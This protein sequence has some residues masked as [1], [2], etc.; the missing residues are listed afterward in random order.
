MVVSCIHN[1]RRADSSFTWHQQCN[2]YIQRCKYIPK[3]KM[4]WLQSLIQKSHA[5]RTQ[6][7]CSRAENSAIYKSDIQ[8]THSLLSLLLLLGLL[9]NT[10]VMRYVHRQ[11]HSKWS[12]FLPFCLSLLPP[13]AVSSGLGARFVC[14]MLQFTVLFEA[15]YVGFMCAYL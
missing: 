11:Y 15:A 9:L 7:I 1:M 5:T 6:L 13:E 10:F 8:P 3:R 14:T 2:N 4:Q 12:Q